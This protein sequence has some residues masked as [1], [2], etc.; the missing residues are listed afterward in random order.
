MKKLFLAFV[1]ACV[2]ALS[3]SASA[4]STVN[5]SVI[6]ESTQESDLFIEGQGFEPLTEM[7]QVAW[8]NY[9]GQLQWRIW[10]ITN[11]K[12]LTEWENA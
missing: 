3:F 2:V 7:V 12:W 10:S 6:T 8:R 5:V 4:F 11:G 1:L 9:Y